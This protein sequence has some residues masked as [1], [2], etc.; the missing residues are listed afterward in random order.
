MK[1]KNRKIEEIIPCDNLADS[2][3]HYIDTLGYKLECIFPSDC[4][5]TAI[6]FNSESR[7]QLGTDKIINYHVPPVEQR[8]VHTR[9]TDSN[10]KIGRVSMQYRD[11]I[12]D[13]QGGRF[14]AS[15]IRVPDGG[16]VPD[17]VHYHD[18]RFQMIYIYKGWVK[19]VYEDQGPPFIMQAG[20]CVLQPPMIR[21]RVLECSDGFEVVE[22]SCP[23]E[24]MTYAEHDIELPTMVFKPERNF[25]GQSFMLHKAENA[26]WQPWHKAGFEYRDLGIAA[27]SKGLAGAYVYRVNG[28]V[29]DAAL[30]HGEEFLFLFILNGKCQLNFINKQNLV[31]GDT[32]V[33]PAQTNY[34]LIG[35]SD[36]LEILEVILP[37]RKK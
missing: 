30:C 24:H 17:Y 6:V 27:S 3:A 5:R 34:S 37:A 35:C 12:P 16:S 26:R 36:D 19:V 13:R 14:I 1:T 25:N 29:A 11:L 23:A 20:D 32:L 15:H 4:P 31:A 22:I 21:H 7:I 10:W 18:V 9:N 8:F 33:I 28:V 2:L